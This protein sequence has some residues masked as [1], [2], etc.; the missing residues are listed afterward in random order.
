MLSLLIDQIETDSRAERRRIENRSNSRAARRRS[1]TQYKIAAPHRSCTSY[2]SHDTK[3]MAQLE[4]RNIL[5]RR[6][7]NQNQRQAPFCESSGSKQSIGPPLSVGGTASSGISLAPEACLLLVL[8]APALS[9]SAG[10][11][12]VSR[13]S[14]ALPRCLAPN[15]AAISR[16]AALMRFEV[17]E[18]T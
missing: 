3:T 1:H 18:C 12:K 10:E 15:R 4:Q 7:Y 9:R 8:G 13:P 14:L 11:A 2:T 16:G 17:T 5:S 6:V